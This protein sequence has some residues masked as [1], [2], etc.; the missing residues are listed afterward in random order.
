MII[1]LFYVGDYLV[2][3]SV[4]SVQVVLDIICRVFMVDVF[5]VGVDFFYVKD[6]NEVVFGV[7]NQNG[8]G[9]YSVCS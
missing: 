9:V 6:V 5:K 8:C 2:V 7:Y 1:F 4:V 3:G